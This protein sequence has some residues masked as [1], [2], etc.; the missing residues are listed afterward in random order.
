MSTSPRRGAGDRIAQTALRAYP[1]GTTPPLV[2]Q[3]SASS[4][5]VLQLGSPAPASPSSIERLWSNFIA[6]SWPPSRRIDAERLRGKAAADP[7]GYDTV[8][9]AY[10]SRCGVNAVSAQNI[11]LQQAMCRWATVDYQVDVQQRAGVGRAHST[12]CIKTS[13]RRHHLR[14]RYRQC[15]R[16]LPSPDQHC[17]RRTDSAPL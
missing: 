17:A 5:P 8:C 10:A 1:P 2:I 12:T 11:I 14:S 6:P 16:R 4:V 15:A 3:Y 7:G 9:Q 13:E